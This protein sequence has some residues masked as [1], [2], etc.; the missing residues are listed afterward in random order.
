MPSFFICV[1]PL[2]EIK[3]TVKQLHYLLMYNTYIAGF[4][5]ETGKV[6][7]HEE[8]TFEE[9]GECL[10]DYKILGYMTDDIQYQNFEYMYILKLLCPS[11]IPRIQIH[12][13]YI[14]E[15]GFF[16]ES[17][18]NPETGEIECR[19]VAGVEFD[20][21]LQKKNKNKKIRRDNSSDD[22]DSDDSDEGGFDESLYC[23]LF[24]GLQTNEALQKL[25]DDG[26]IGYTIEMDQAKK[27]RVLKRVFGSPRQQI[28]DLFLYS[29][30]F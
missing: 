13:K 18:D 4:D 26:Y 16:L 6:E 10:N 11:H 14:E 1:Y 28:R 19:V 23:D 9:I 2:E 8:I 21:K 30:L 22:S 20:H 24:F 12:F 5:D 3:F 15:C 17:Y 29:F 25:K 7:D 27:E